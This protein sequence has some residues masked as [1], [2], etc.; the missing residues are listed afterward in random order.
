M[1]SRTLYAVLYLE[2]NLISFYIFRFP[3]EDFHQTSA[4]QQFSQLVSLYVRQKLKY[5]S[6][7]TRQI[8]IFDR[9]SPCRQIHAAV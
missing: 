8:S 9:N 5:L 3:S 7:Y 4:F 2:I 1:D 6:F